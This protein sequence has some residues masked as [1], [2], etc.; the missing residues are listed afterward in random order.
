MNK[1]G[2]I[3]RVSPGAGIPGGEVMIECEALDVSEPSQCAALVDGEVA[4][5]VALSAKR[6]L[7]VVPE[8]KRAR[9]A[10]WDTHSKSEAGAAPE[11]GQD[12]QK[13]INR[14]VDLV[15]ESQG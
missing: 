5:L 6:V 8:L 14:A 12:P 10:R 11:S 9:H 7:A 3:L 13:Q 15:L 1:G 2:K 4:P